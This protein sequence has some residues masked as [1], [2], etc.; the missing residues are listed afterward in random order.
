M[1]EMQEKFQQKLHTVDAEP[2]MCRVLGAVIYG[3]GVL[4][5]RSLR[6]SFAMHAVRTCKCKFFCC[7]ANRHQNRTPNPPVT[8]PR[9]VYSSSTCDVSNM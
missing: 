4:G 1:R 6:V 5:S 8:G 3:C 7:G 9:R 2:L